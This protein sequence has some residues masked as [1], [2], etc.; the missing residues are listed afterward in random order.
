MRSPIPS[1]KGGVL[2]THLSVRTDLSPEKRTCREAFFPQVTGLMLLISDYILILFPKL[3][4]LKKN[5]MFL[6]I[7]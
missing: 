7:H 2:I 5:Y 1:V 6:L 4:I 3:D